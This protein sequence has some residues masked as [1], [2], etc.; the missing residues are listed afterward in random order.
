MAQQKTVRMTRAQDKA[1]A[2]ATVP[3]G[4]VAA[5]KLAGWSVVKPATSAKDEASD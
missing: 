3:V 1:V 4:D 2:E 5:W